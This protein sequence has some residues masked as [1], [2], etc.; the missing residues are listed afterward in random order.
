MI[1]PSDL[2]HSCIFWFHC[3]IE[4]G[5]SSTKT[6]AVSLLRMRNGFL[7][8]IIKTPP[9]NV[10]LFAVLFDQLENIEHLYEN[11]LETEYCLSFVSLERFAARSNET[12]PYFSKS[13]MVFAESYRSPFCSSSRTFSRSLLAA[14]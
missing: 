4:C 13:S 12:S 11:D 2:E 14:A 6:L 3:N 1:V 8:G 7:V 5:A 10:P 9:G